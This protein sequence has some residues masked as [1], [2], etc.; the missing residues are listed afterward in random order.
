MDARFFR[1]TTRRSAFARATTNPA[2]AAIR[3]DRALDYAPVQATRHT[4]A[5]RRWMKA[6]ALEVHVRDFEHEA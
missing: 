4:G 1:R 6:K 2:V 5:D 3:R